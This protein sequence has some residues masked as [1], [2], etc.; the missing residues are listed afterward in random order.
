MNDLASALPLYREIIAQSYS[1]FTEL[2]LIKASTIQFNNKNYQDAYSMF[3]SLLEVAQNQQ[4][5]SYA[6]TGMIRSAYFLGNYNECITSG[7]QLL[8]D[9][10]TPLE[11]LPEIHLIMARSYLALDN[12]AE[13]E[14]AFQKVIEN[15]RNEWAA[16]SAYQLAY[17]SY[18]KGD[19]PTAEKRIYDLSDNYSSFDYW[20]AKG[21]ILLSD[22]FVALGDTF[23]AKE[24][25]QS[26]IENYQGEDLLTVAREK[27]ALLN[28]STEN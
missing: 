20:V 22:V 11:S 5:R 26:I 3:S 28:G 9:A 18:L 27:L 19:H 25:L 14:V 16:E 10:G 24:T 6:L 4:N 7:R 15:S 21:F 17:I 12:L 8:E 2:S 23:Q 13:A 1:E